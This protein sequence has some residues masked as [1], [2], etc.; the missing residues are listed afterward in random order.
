MINE[1]AVEQARNTNLV[2][3]VE[4][5]VE[6]HKESSTEWSGPCPRCGGHDR[7]HVKATGFFC[8]NRSCWPDGA[9][10]FGDPIDYVR[11][12]Y[13]V[14]FTD[15]IQILTGYAPAPSPRKTVIA[16]P[17]KRDEPRQYSGWAEKVTPMVEAAQDR[18]EEAI[19]YLDSRKL[20]L[21]TAMLFGLGFRPDAPL[22]GTWNAKTR[23]HIHP[24]QPAIVIPWYR[25]NKVVAIRYRF[26][27]NH[28][29]TDVDG[30]QRT[31]KLSSV[32]DSDFKGVL[33]GGHMLPEFCHLP[34]DDNGRCA[35]QLR[36][37]VLCEGEINLLSI[38]QVVN[39][40]RWDVL[41]VGSE[42]QKLTEPMRLFAA[43][44]ERVIV[45]M[46]KAD[47]VRRLMS[48]LGGAVGVNSPDDRDANELLKSGQLLDFLVEVRQAAC[49]T[50]A[51]RE[52]FKWDLWER[53]NHG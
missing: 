3:L 26:L 11:W 42:S 25:A 22:P 13:G 15:A 36:T 50:D 35:E 38:W 7:L 14:N 27:S 29:Y 12:L 51:E 46:D 20:E 8:R 16:Q 2:G 41:S 4:Q 37:L 9:D 47:V 32:H 30:K 44:Y 45:W 10:K 24:P 19:N 48:Q 39:G 23:S 5:R 33:Y 1:M 28:T 49:K 52:R 21:S 40:L 43:R 53:G 34:I 6:L 17:P 18:I 31:V